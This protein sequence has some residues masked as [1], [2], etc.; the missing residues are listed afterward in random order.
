MVYKHGTKTLR[1]VF[2]T[3]SWDDCDR[4]TFAKKYVGKKITVRVYAYKTID[5]VRYLSPVSAVK[6]VRLAR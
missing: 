2:K 1:T 3:D 4:S 6:S 5:G